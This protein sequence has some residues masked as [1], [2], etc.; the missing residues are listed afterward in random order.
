MKHLV[1]LLLTFC[2][3]TLAASDPLF[4][5]V[6]EKISVEA[7]PPGE[8]AVEFGF[9]ARYRNLENVSGELPLEVIE[10]EGAD[11]FYSPPRFAKYNL[12]R[13]EVQIV[14]SMYQHHA[15]CF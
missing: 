6:G 5:F 4:V 11:E 8:N 7:I 3:L 12:G 14:V 9:K 15:A 2:A 1:V 10:F 13:A